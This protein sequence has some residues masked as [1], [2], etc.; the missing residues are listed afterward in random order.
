MKT[1]KAVILTKKDLSKAGTIKSEDLQ[2][3][4]QAELAI[5]TSPKGNIVIKNKFGPIDVKAAM[6]LV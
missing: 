1:V 5:Y 3:I 6:Q 4:F 2:R